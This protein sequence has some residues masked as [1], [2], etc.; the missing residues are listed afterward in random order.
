MKKIQVALASFGMSGKVFHGPLLKANKG[1]IVKKIYERS[2]NESA[3]MFPDSEIV[4]NYSKIIND[5]EIDLVIVNVPDKLHYSF[6]K[7]ALKAGK[8]VV[9]EK[10][11]V[12]DIMEGEELIALAGKSDRVL[13]VF[14]NRRWDSDFLTVEKVMKEGWL[15][16]IREF[17]A[18]F[19]RFKDAVQK[20]TWKEDPDEGASVLFNLGSHLVDQVLMLFSM[21]HS[22]FAD[23]AKVRE[24]SRI[25]D[26]FHIHLYYQ[27]FKVIL[28]SSYQVKEPG[29]KFMIHGT[30]G[31]F[32]K[33]GMDPQEEEL[34]NGVLPV[35]PDWGNE[36]EDAYGILT[37]ANEEGDYKRK[38]QSLPGNYPFFYQNLYETLTGGVN[39]A[40]WP[41]EALN[42][43]KILKAVEK[44][45]RKRCV[46]KLQGVIIN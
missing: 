31:S 24:E 35:G 6:A 45:N 3:S 25:L 46:V 26:Y 15:G 43:I 27:G 39:L 13:T 42:V 18:H 40:V 23:L 41:Q 44:S 1:F 12:L 28:K 5:P 29:P 10:P 21:P 38:L 19:D 7:A 8:H 22:V 20:G 14:Q 16:E 11:F 4:R 17:E 36:P 32:L 2:K 33:Y 30:K 9:L 34:K 37:T